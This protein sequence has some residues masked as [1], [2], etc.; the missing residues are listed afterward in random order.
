MDGEV[1]DWREQN[2]KSLIYQDSTNGHFSFTQQAGKYDQFLFLLFEVQDSD[3]ATLGRPDSEI[4]QVDHIDLTLGRGEADAMQF[5][6]TLARA[7]NLQT[8]RVLTSDDTSEHLEADA[9]IQAAWRK[10]KFGY[11]VE[12]KVPLDMI[13]GKIGFDVVNVTNTAELQSVDHLGARKE[14]LS[15]VIPGVENDSI[16]RGTGR[17]SARVWVVDFQT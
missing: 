16:L 14:L 9:R 17:G 15:V 8:F 11:R 7:P 4:D 13:G 1:S 10:S 2:V 3:V 6:L 5:R 12:V